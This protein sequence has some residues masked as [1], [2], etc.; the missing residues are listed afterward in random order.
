MLLLVEGLGIEPLRDMSLHVADEDRSWWETT[1][2]KLGLV[3]VR[4]AVLAPTGSWLSKRSPVDRFGQLIEPLQRR[5]FERIIVVGA[6]SEVDQVKPLSADSRTG[7]SAL[8]NL[9]GHAKI[10]Q[11]MAVIAQ[12]GLIVANDSAPLH[13]AVGFDRPC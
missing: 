2:D 12:A 6:P 10:G 3:D 11:T 4:Y 7:S 9:V 8:I 5:G 1:R 13:M